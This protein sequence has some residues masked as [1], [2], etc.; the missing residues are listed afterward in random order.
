MPPLSKATETSAKREKLF[1]NIDALEKAASDPNANLP[2]DLRQIIATLRSLTH[3]TLKATYEMGLD[4]GKQ[5]T[6]QTPLP[7]APESNS[8]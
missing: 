4:D 3:K 2:E 5:T 8:L 6:P 1:G 7:L